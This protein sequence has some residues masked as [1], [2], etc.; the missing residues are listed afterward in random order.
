ML[1]TTEAIPQIF[2]ECVSDA[3]H[4]QR[5]KCH[6]AIFDRTRTLLK[7]VLKRSKLKRKCY[8]SLPMLSNHLCTDVH[9][10]TLDPAEFRKALE[11]FGVIDRH[12]KDKNSF[13]SYLYVLEYVL[14]K[15]Q[16]QDLCPFLSRIQCKTRRHQYN[17][18]LDKIFG[19]RVPVL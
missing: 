6:V 7:A 15:M 3:K 10:P 18:L 14:H 16:R 2:I 1:H 5:A 19:E 13:I 9:V 8:D 12:Y 17:I 11:Y 4:D